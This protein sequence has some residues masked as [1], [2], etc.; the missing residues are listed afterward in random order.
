MNFLQKCDDYQ[1][2]SEDTAKLLLRL[3]VGGTVLL[4]GIF[5]ITH[6]EAIG[7]IGGLFATW[8]LPMFLAYLIYLGEVVAPLLVILGW[9]TKVGA[10]LIAITMLIAIVLAHPGDILS[11]N[12]MGGWGI[13]LQALMLFGAI[14]ISGLGAGK[15]GLDAKRKGETATVL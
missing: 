2:M 15:Y 8:H 4:H 5:K 13:E 3:V 12:D 9:Y 10:R 11:L 6:P 1:C 14:A 7:F